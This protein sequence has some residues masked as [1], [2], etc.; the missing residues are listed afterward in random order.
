MLRPRDRLPERIA[1]SVGQLLITLSITS[2]CAAL[3]S[4]PLPWLWVSSWLF[5]T[6]LCISALDYWNDAVPCWRPASPNILIASNCPNAQAFARQLSYPAILHPRESA[7]AW[8]SSEQIDKKINEVVIFDTRLTTSEQDCLLQAIRRHN[9][10]LHCPTPEIAPVKMSS[11]FAAAQKRLFDILSSSL[12]IACSAPLL[13]IVAMI[14]RLQDGS[15]PIFRQQR[16]GMGGTCIT[17]LKFR[18]MQVT[19]GDDP[20]APQA[21]DQDP[22]I[23]P[24]GRWIRYWGIDELPQLF[25]VLNGDMSMVGPRPH[26]VAHDL[27]YGAHIDEYYLRLAARPGITGLAQIRGMR[28]ETRTTAAMQRRIDADLEYLSRQSLLLD[29]FILAATPIALLRSGTTSLCQD[30]QDTPSEVSVTTEPAST[31]D[32]QQPLS[33]T[34]HQTTSEAESA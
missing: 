9:L 7:I 22:R 26:A 15:S 21:K 28:G 10:R 25:N 8:L 30:E 1:T 31:T 11:A 23:T 4:M 6:T 24:F 16:L 5:I 34:H 18:S 19:A 33:N 32:R 13:L 20:L 14:V 17:V 27:H 2:S 3:L 12:L 29:L